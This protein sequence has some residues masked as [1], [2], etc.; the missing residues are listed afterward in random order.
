MKNERT[1][2]AADTMVK[3][4]KAQATEVTFQKRM[5][6]YDKDEVDRYIANLSEAYQAAYE[7]HAFIS[8]KYDSLLE[9]YKTLDGE[10]ETTYDKITQV[11]SE[12]LGILAPH[13]WDLQAK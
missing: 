8:A 7:E 5:N 13:P 4:K 6:G 9:E 12:M 10:R 2:Q 3:I 11:V 1:N